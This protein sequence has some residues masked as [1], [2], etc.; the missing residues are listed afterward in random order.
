MVDALLVQNPTGRVS[1]RSSF[2]KP[3][4]PQRPMIPVEYAVAAY[5]FGHSMIRAEYELRD[6]PDSGGQSLTRPIFS[7]DGQDLRGSRPLPA[8]LVL[9]WNY[10]FDVPG[11]DSPD[12]RNQARQI[13]TQVARPLHDLPPTVVLHT[14][15]AVLAL[16]ER[17][18]LRGERLGNADLGLTEAGWGGKAPLWFYI[19]KEAELGG[20]RRLGPV[21]GRIVAE[22]ILDL[23]GTDR[24]SYFN[25]RSRFSPVVANCRIGD[26]LRLAGA[27]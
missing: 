17:N 1:V 23:L 15:A 24:S 9:D 14:A 16:A 26:L 4:N 3:G 5:C 20:G 21:G 22:V 12:D 7:P 6:V 11:L 25:A 19:L 27:A 8:E 10:F 18:L 2:Y 13:D